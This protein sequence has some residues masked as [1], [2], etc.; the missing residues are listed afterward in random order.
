MGKTA[1][2]RKA[3]GEI[4]NY[5]D[6]ILMVVILMKISNIEIQ[7]FIPVGGSCL[8]RVHNLDKK[9]IQKDRRPSHAINTQSMMTL[10]KFMG[11]L[12]LEDCFLCAH[13]RQK[14]YI[15]SNTVSISWKDIH[16]LYK[17]I[18]QP[19]IIY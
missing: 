1:S 6:G 3:K 12:D 9:V 10:L 18:C 11:I 14:R 8:N 2:N 17:K 7:I 19:R 16:S 5:G 4:S 15:V 13:R